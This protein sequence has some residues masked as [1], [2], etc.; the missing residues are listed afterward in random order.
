MDRHHCDAD[1]DTTFHFDGEPDP[2]KFY[3]FWQYETLFN[4]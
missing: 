1:L 2:T 3:K 4:F